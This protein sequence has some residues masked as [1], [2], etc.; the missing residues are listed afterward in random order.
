MEWSADG[1]RTFG[2][3]DQS[4]ENRRIVRKDTVTGEEKFISTVSPRWDLFRLSPDGQRLAFLQH[5]AGVEGETLSVVSTDGGTP[6][7]LVAHDG[8]QPWFSWLTPSTAWSPDGRYLLFAIESH[9]PEHGA[10]GGELWVVPA[11][12]GQARKTELVTHD[13]FVGELNVHP[14][15][16][17]IGYSMKSWQKEYW[18]LENFLPASAA[19]K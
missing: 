12:G 10:D 17:R 4:G 2:T 16:K 5:Q 1:R 8:K 19:A 14:D 18:V 3:F 7:P 13:A 11:D 9:A 15:G 6:L